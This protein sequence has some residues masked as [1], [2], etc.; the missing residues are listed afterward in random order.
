MACDGCP[1][2]PELLARYADAG[3][4]YQV[5]P[6]CSNAKDPKNLIEHAQVGGPV[7]MWQ[8]IGGEGATSFSY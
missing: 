3:G 1:P 4:T 6:L 7:P 5:R 8:W 2:L